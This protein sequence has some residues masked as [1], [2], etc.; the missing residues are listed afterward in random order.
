MTRGRKVG[1][2]L[3]LAGLFSMFFVP[4][5]LALWLNV[6]RPDWLPFGTVN[7]GELIEPTRQ[8]DAR[9][10]EFFDPGAIGA[11]AFREKWTLL[12]VTGRACDSTCRK[13]LDMSSRARR[14]LGDDMARLQ[15][16]LVLSN[17][18]R[19]AFAQLAREHPDL[20]LASA[21]ARWLERLASGEIASA[22]L[23][24]LYLIDPQGYLLMRYPAQTDIRGLVKDLERLLRI[25]KI[26]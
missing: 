20:R 9:A 14:A 16:L 7:R 21:P 24:H 6:Y 18:P 5:L 26:G 2:R 3:M 17:A 23:H 8:L 4:V 13:V 12:Y 25:S 1:P 15:R 19:A 11:E 22:A 10:L